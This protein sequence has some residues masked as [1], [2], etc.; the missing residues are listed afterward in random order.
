[1]VEEMIGKILGVTQNNF[2]VV[3]KVMEDEN[4]TNNY[5]LNKNNAVDPS[6]YNLSF[7]NDS[8][9]HLVYWKTDKGNRIITNIKL[10]STTGETLDVYDGEKLNVF[11][12]EVKPSAPEGKVGGYTNYEGKTYDEK[13]YLKQI[14]F[15]LRKHFD[16]KEELK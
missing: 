8:E 11:E 10:L 5:F 1:M 6:K 13:Y 9:C 16:G 14:Y 15:M 4:N 3:L 7:L 12:S 2:G